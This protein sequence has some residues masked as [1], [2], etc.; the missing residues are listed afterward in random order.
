[1]AGKDL[2]GVQAFTLDRVGKLIQ[3]RFWTCKDADEARGLAEGR[4]NGGY[5][6]GAAAFYRTG[7][8]EFDEGEAVT[9]AT[10]GRVPAGVIDALPF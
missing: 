5:V 6:A 8:G 9:I 4:V 1:M 3:G 7:A 10:Y 2:Y